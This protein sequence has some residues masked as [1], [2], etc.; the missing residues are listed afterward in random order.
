MVF[1]LF[2]LLPLSA[3]ADTAGSKPNSGPSPSTGVNPQLQAS[4]IAAQNWLGL[5]DKESYGQSWDQASALMKLTIKKGEWET[6]LNKMRKPL[7]SVLNRQVLDQRTAKNPHG[8][9]QGD[10]MVLFYKTDFSRKSS[11]YELV[12]LFLE[13]GEWRV[14]TYQ[15]D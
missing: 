2:T 5:V 6:F 14:M 15:V 3:F 12:T 7:G 1:F 8:L 9:P 13:D 10:Y 11:A 4:A